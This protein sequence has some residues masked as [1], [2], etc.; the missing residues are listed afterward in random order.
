MPSLLLGE[1]AV[2]DLRVTSGTGIPLLELVAGEL[3]LVKAWNVRSRT[4]HI[5]VGGSPGGTEPHFEHLCQPTRL[6]GGDQVAF[7]VYGMVIHHLALSRPLV[8][9]A[10]MPN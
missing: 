1:V 4:Q 8:R 3:L 5:P 6:R 10:G 2:C 9:C 7:V